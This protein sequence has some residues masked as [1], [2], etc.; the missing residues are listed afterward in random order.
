MKLLARAI[1][2][3]ISPVILGYERLFSPA[4]RPR[5]PEAQAQVDAQ[6]RA[7]ALYEFRA[8]PYCVKV[9]MEVRR[10]GLNVELR[11]VRLEERYAA[12][13]IQQGGEY[14]VP[15]LRIEEDGATRWLYESDEIIRFLRG[16][17][18]SI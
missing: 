7:L 8:C 18:A 15:C 16:R 2:N 9:R 6:T 3:V 5:T 12:E 14:Q 13:L 4:P 1:R 10:L 11:D 17:F